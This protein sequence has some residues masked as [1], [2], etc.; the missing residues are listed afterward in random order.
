MT[1]EAITQIFGY[2]NGENSDPRLS[3][4]P[5]K[6]E[7]ASQAGVD[8]AITIIHAQPPCTLDQ[9]VKMAASFGQ[10][11]CDPPEQVLNIAKPIIQAQLK[12]A[13]IAIPAE[14]PLVRPGASPNSLG[15]LKTLRLIMRLSPLV[16][17]AFLLGITI[18]VVRSLKG[19]LAWWGWP[20]LFA[21][22][23]SAFSGFASAPSFR[24]LV[25]RFLAR[26]LPLTFPPDITNTLRAVADAAI[27]QMLHPAGWEGLVMAAI[28]L[29]MILVSFAVSAG[30]KAKRLARS[31]AKTQIF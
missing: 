28:G 16:P 14:V 3:L 2:L 20:L 4:L 19:W 23:F 15:E 10:E 30:E 5:L 7:L 12:A 9:L 21:G 17:L 18:L 24:L 22:S 27:R 25:E 13:A 6:S 11:L 26:R 31:E 29:I 8:A 1:E